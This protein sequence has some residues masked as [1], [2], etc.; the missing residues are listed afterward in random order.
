MTHTLALCLDAPMQSWGLRSRFQSRD[1]AHEPTKSGVIGLLAAALGIPRDLDREIQRL[2]KV[3][4]GVRVD[5][6]GLVER[7]FHTVNNVPNTEGANPRTVISHRYYLA[8][9]VFL[10]ALQHPDRDELLRWHAALLN[11][12]WPIYLGRRAFVPAR[13]LVAPAPDSP[14]LGIADAPLEDVLAQHDWL[15][16]RT[17]PHQRLAKAVSDGDEHF[18]R[19]L[20]DT[21]PTDELAEP[22][23]DVPV[24]FHPR[25]RLFE[26]RSV[27]AGHVQLTASMIHTGAHPCT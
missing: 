25:N 16:N 20:V 26:T 10:V 7:D 3:R 15:E 1:T 27:R 12:H 13:P 19:T 22:R 9:A 23:R 11:P 4:M 8:D 5:R 21:S 2:A 6:E 14:W 24:S 17:A 18:L